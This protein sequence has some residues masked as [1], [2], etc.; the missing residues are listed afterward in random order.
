MPTLQRITEMA[1]RTLAVERVG[2]WRYT[3]DRTAIQCMDLYELSHDRHAA[4]MTLPVHSFPG[5]FDA[6][7]KSRIIAADDAH[8]DDR[9]AGFSAEYLSKSGISSLMDVPIYLFGR[10]EGVICH[11]HVGPARRWT[12][13]EEMFS[14]PCRILSLLPMNRGNAGARK[15]SSNN[16]RNGS[17]A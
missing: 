17:E 8:T 2:I 15:S 14:P 16:P 10:L 6:L 7:V 13:D 3:D 5:Y 11:E 12:E 4:E 1:A 9:T